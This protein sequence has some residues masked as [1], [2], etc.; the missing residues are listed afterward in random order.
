MIKKNKSAPETES[1]S[2]LPHERE[3]YSNLLAS[4]IQRK[5]DVKRKAKESARDFKRQIEECEEEELRLSNAI[6]TGVEEVPLKRQ[7]TLADI[8]DQRRHEL[9]I[10]DFE[11]EIGE[12]LLRKDGDLASTE[13]AS[14]AELK[15]G[16]GSKKKRL[17]IHDLAKQIENMGPVS[18][19]DLH[20]LGY[21]ESTIESA[22][23]HKLIVLSEKGLAHH[24]DKFVAAGSIAESSDVVE[25][26]PLD[27][28]PD[29]KHGR[30]WG[31]LSDVELAQWR[32]KLE[33]KSSLADLLT[34]GRDK[35]AATYLERVQAEISRRDDA[36]RKADSASAD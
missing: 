3:E 12:A 7:M 13:A 11:R 2:L 22:V 16:K 20:V 19:G 28:V 27:L 9:S 1:R 32:K 4:T 29:D 8:E 31:S 5:R 34:D 10:T 15:Q 30:T 24:D 23:I 26:D 14:T 36:W 35:E 6:I 33:N 25:T 17:T 18:R 21:R